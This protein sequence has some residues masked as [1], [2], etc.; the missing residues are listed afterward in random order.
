MTR[1]LMELG[2]GGISQIAD[3]GDDRDCIPGERYCMRS[4]GGG[5]QKSIGEKQDPGQA[6]GRGG[7]GRGLA[8]NPAWLNV[9]E[10]ALESDCLDLDPGSVMNSCA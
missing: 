5:K 4:F 10:C 6:G 9:E 1:I 2:C 8:T 3:G 7:W